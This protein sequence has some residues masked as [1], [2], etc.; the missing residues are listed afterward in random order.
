MDSD[1]K[2]IITWLVSTGRDSGYAIEFMDDLRERLA[3]R[4]QLSTDGHKAYLEAVEGAFGGYVDYGQLVKLYGGRTRR[5]PAVVTALP[6]MSAQRGFGS[7]GIQ[8]KRT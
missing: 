1:S 3:N 4:V 7:S 8:P 2:L 5:F 6:I